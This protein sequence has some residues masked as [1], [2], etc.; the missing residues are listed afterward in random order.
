MQTL[1]I[2]L[3]AI[4][5]IPLTIGYLFGAMDI[6]PDTPEGKAYYDNE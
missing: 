1:A 5:F 3:G 4:L 2:S 6:D